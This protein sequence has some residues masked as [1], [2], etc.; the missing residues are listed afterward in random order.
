MLDTN[1]YKILFL[2]LYRSDL[3]PNQFLRSSLGQGRP[4]NGT[5]QETRL[6]DASVPSSLQ[7]IQYAYGLCIYGCTYIYDNE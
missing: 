6:Y 5:R 7:F 1:K 2:C 3:R 4:L